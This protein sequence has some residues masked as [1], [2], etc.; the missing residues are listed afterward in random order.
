[1]LEKRCDVLGVEA[2]VWFAEVDV[3]GTQDGVEIAADIELTNELAESYSTFVA[4]QNGEDV[5]GVEFYKNGS[6]S[7]EEV[8]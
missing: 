7:V 1:L 4:Y 3:F 5:L 8:G 6:G 2:C